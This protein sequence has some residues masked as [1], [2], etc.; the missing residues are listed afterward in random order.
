MAKPA[1]TQVASGA[2]DSCLAYEYSSTL[3]IEA[4]CSS[5]TLV[6]FEWTA[7][8]YIPEYSTVHIHYCE[9]LKSY[10]LDEWYL[11]DSTAVCFGTA[12]IYTKLPRNSSAGKYRHMPSG[13]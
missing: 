1:P 6:E 8:R 9:N 5:E 12:A 11:N 4:I 10:M 7:R 2:L 3:K 13:V